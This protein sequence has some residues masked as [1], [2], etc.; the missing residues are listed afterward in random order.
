MKKLIKYFLDDRISRARTRMKDAAE[1]SARQHAEVKYHS[2]LHYFHEDIATYIDPNTNWWTFADHKQ[3]SLD[4]S[5]E[6]SRWMDRATT[7]DAKLNAA[8]LR[9]NKLRNPN[10][11]EPQPTQE[12]SQ[13]D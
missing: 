7:A 2:Y 12:E 3:K 13:I 9:L 1:V 10:P 8:A 4:H 11:V 5:N 6:M